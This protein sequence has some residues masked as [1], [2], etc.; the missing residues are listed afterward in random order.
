MNQVSL[1]GKGFTLIE[2]MVVMA[3]IAVLGAVAV[4]VYQ[5][6][7]ER[8]RGV[9]IVVEY[10]A[11]RTAVAAQS[12]TAKL[13]DCAELAKGFAALPAPAA[14]TLS[15]GFEA[16]TGGYRPVLTVCAQAGK[17]G[18]QGVKTARSAY[19]T[20]SKNGVVEKDPVLTD[21]VVSFALRLT[22]GGQVLC[23]TP[24]A[25][26]TTAC[27]QPATQAGTPPKADAAALAAAVQALPVVQALPQAEQ[28]AVGST[29]AQMAAD[30][31]YAKAVAEAIAQAPPGQPVGVPA[32]AKALQ[33]FTAQCPA[34]KLGPPWPAVD[35]Y[36]GGTCPA[37]IVASCN[38]CGPA[39]ICPVSCGLTRGIGPDAQKALDASWR[40]M[41]RRTCEASRGA[42]NPSCAQPSR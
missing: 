31:N 24:P 19:E 12:Q 36:V 3:I 9:D 13:D 41:R 27:G 4:V 15:Y 14:A 35:N 33:D 11:I 29:A 17:N 25:Q 42:G 39:M 1:H 7:I 20:L 18:P 10:D 2:L 21:S 34:N 28:Q 26:A 22:D 23:K 38:Q 30:P 8:A 16:V 40:E 37:S 5:K 6:Y 32:S